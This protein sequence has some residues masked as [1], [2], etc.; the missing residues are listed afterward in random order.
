MTD[1]T[2]DRDSTFPCKEC[3][4]PLNFQPG[5][6]SMKC[7]FCG[8]ENQIE[9][10]GGKTSPWGEKTE[11]T[12]AGLEELDYKA[13]L[14]NRL[15]ADDIEETTTIKCPACGAEVGMDSGTLADECPFCATPL[16][17]DAAH[18]HR[19]PKPQGVLPFA[20]DERSARD[21]MKAWLGR[22]WFAPNSLKKF[23]EAGRPLSGV[24]L[25]HYTYDA[26]G[27]ADYRGQRGD[28]YYVTQTRTVM[29]DG[30]PQTE[31]YQERRVNWTN[32]SGHVRHAFDDVL[33]Q[34]SDTM[35]P[36]TQTAEYGGAS[37]DLSA[38]EPYR[39]EFLA[40][41]RAEA[42]ALALE[43]GYNRANQLMEQTLVRDIKFDIGGDEQHI[44]SMTS[45]YSDITFKHVLLP[46]WLASYRWNN[47]AFRVVVNGRT[48]QVAG[49]RPY[50]AWK[51]AFAVLLGLIVAGGIGYVYAMSQGGGF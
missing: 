41:F 42:P 12:G 11:A 22:L 2:A 14:A 39:K 35:G 15:D 45:S 27:D 28:A 6:T 10:S 50:S 49:E 5:A 4:G 34:A 19:H 36:A 13:A 37:W 25:P 29:V 40:G 32:V 21:K 9:G 3:G 24:Y 30:K 38:L 1:T 17:K 26:V 7:P 33:V 48:G 16:A 18:S 31:T 43:D 23:A 44:S 20:F 51:I 47:K 46:V 8:T